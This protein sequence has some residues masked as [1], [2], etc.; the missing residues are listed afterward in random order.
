MRDHTEI[1]IIFDDIPEYT[2]GVNDKLEAL[3][4]K[5]SQDILGDAQLLIQ[6]TQAQG[7]QYGAHRASAPG[8]PPANDTSNLVNSGRVY[9]RG[10]LTR[11]ITFNAEYAAPLEF[12]S[13]KMA[14]RPFMLPTIN[15]F[16]D[17]FS[18]SIAEVLKR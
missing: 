16:L 18:Q 14:A 15:K 1:K 6:S 17:I 13:K 4:E 11:H 3:V 2:Q 7:I 12:G 5:T 9:K 8:D 10:K